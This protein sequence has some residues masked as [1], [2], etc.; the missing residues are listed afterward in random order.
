MAIHKIL[1]DDFICLDYELIAVHAALEDYRMAYLLNKYFNI[2][3]QKNRT[4]I[5]VQDKMGRSNFNH[6]YYDDEKNGI[7]WN[8][9]ENKAFSNNSVKNASGIF[10]TVET[11]SYL[12]PEY[13]NAK[14]IVKI[15]NSENDY[16]SKKIIQQL[17]QLQI[18]SLVYEIP[19]DNLKSKNNLIF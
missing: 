7:I 12:L 18:V 1:I 13:K 14:F 17:A 6:F 10:E 16:W 11:A 3:L 2:Q 4:N 15:E 8:L 9:V 19:V 5:T